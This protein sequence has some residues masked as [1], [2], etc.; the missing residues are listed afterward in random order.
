MKA[1]YYTKNNEE[2]L[3]E[4]DGDV[5]EKPILC[6][7]GKCRKRFPFV[8]AVTKKRMMYNIEIEEK[9]CPYCGSK[10]FSPTDQL[11]WLNQMGTLHQ[12]NGRGGKGL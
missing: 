9:E 3:G 5:K 2:F 8:K 10:G 4:T 7:C 1:L 11:Y 6:I 12:A